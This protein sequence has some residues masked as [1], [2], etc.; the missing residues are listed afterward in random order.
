MTANVFWLPIGARLKRIS[1][2]ECEQMELVIEGILAIQSG[3]NPRLVEQKLLSLLPNAPKQ[4][5]KEVA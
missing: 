3:S 2:T 1:Q 4:D 5:E